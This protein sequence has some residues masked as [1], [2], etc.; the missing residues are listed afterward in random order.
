MNTTPAGAAVPHRARRFA[1]VLALLAVAA[2]LAVWL[3]WARK[4]AG[5]RPEPPRPTGV[6]DPEVAAVLDRA[7]EKAAESH[8]A[9]AWGEYGLVLLAHQFEAQAAVCVEEAGRLDPRNPRWPYARA[10]MAVKREAERAPDFLRRALDADNGGPYR[11]NALFL[12]GDV[13]VELGK[14]DEAAEAYA[15]AL[16]SAPGHPRAELGLGQVALARG[17]AGTARGRLE[18]AA[19]DARSALQAHA[20]LAQLARGEGDEGRARAHEKAAAA[21]PPAQ[22]WP[23]ALLEHV[24]SL[25]VGRQARARRAGE[26]EAEGR[27]LEAAELHLKNLTQDRSVRAL[28]GAG[29]NLAQAGD[30]DRGVQLLREAVA[31]EPGD[32]RARTTL[33]SVL[34]A[35]AELI[36]LRN[37]AAPAVRPLFEEAAELARRA[38]ADKPDY[39]PAYLYWGASLKYLGN[40]KGAIEP[41]R[42]GLAVRPDDF[43][44]NLALGQVLA[45]TGDTRG[46]EASFKNAQALNPDDPRP[47]AELKK[48][49]PGK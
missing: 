24:V 38:A 48:L 16:A 35:R 42:T 41:L 5:A 37:P 40:P 9:E 25:Q 7:R 19:G 4:S 15:S 43:E 6:E 46:A 8:T 30:F 20:L 2:G 32:G 26:L 39:A 49:N 14:P 1:L 3:V 27:H 28:V 34:F 17:D 12:L 33:A 47:S 23:D 18:R 29:F 21:S 31:R 10:L 22:P 11:T 13:L 36:S 44:M 45:A